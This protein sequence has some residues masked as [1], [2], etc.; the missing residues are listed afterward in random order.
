MR[1]TP[2]VVPTHKREG[3]A[4]S[5]TLKDGRILRRLIEKHGRLLCSPI[6]QEGKVWIENSG[7]KRAPAVS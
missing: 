1:A 2:Q 5:L 3:L 6:S 4:G 7:W